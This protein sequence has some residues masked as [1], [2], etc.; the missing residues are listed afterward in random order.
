MKKIAVALILAF[1]AMAVTEAQ[2]TLAPTV[3]ASA[4]GY[5]EAGNISLSWT[6]GELAVTTLNSG[7][8]I[9]TQGFQQPYAIGTGIN[10]WLTDWSI[11]AYPNPVEKELRLRFDIEE[12]TDFWI[13]IQDVAGRIMSQQQY[14][15]IIPGQVLPVDMQYFTHG[16]Y[17]FKVFTPDRSQVRVLSIRKM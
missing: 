11:I 1:S 16:I 10:P 2:I 15:H 12:P 17:F 7:D 9:L 4:G 5:S 8:L 3:I 14:K 13:E 6:L